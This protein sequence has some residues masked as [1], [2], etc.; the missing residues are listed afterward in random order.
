MRKLILI[1]FAVAAALAL[2]ATTGAFAAG[3]GH[4]DSNGRI[5]VTHHTL[6][7]NGNETLDILTMEPNGSD[8]RMLTN[9]ASG[10][11]GGADPAWARDSNRIYFDSDRAGNVHVFAMNAN[12]HGV[13]QVTETDG[14]E[15]TPSVSN[16]GRLL[17]FE[18]DNADF[19]SGGIFV[20]DKHG[21][22]LGDFR[23]ITA[24]PAL[25]VGG[26]DGD[27]DVSP[28]GR[29]VAFMRL[30]D[31]THGSAQSAVF[32]VGVDGR[33]L[34]QL[35]PYSLNA[36]RPSWSPDGSRIAFSSN[37]DNFPTPARIWVVRANG[38]DLTQLTKEP[39]GQGQDFLP[40][41]SPDGTKIV[42]DRFVGESHFD[43]VTIDPDGS[44]PTTIWHGTDG[45]FDFRP[46]WGTRDDD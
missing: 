15:F 20:S 41:W 9:A 30:I 26:F 5:A 28:D 19:S 38:S 44:N 22:T 8:P 13:K 27:P 14:F 35:T 2:A 7:P 29:K 25:A 23:Q 32:V 39:A 21:G 17:A 40:D 31:T 16:D 42:Y 43:L 18:H 10:G 11:F 37:S 45:T 12:G 4:G 1:A 33:G 6:L 34:R 24:S 46:A 3:S 36:A